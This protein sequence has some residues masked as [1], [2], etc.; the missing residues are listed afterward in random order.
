MT[1]SLVSTPWVWSSANHASSMATGKSGHPCP[2]ILSE[3]KMHC[4]CSILCQKSHFE[5]NWSWWGVACCAWSCCSSGQCFSNC[6]KS[7]V[8]VLPEDFSVTV[9]LSFVCFFN[10]LS[11]WIDIWLVFW[12]FFLFSLI[13]PK[14][15]QWFYNKQ[16]LCGPQI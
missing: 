8:T 3:I 16:I 6:H 9:K 14:Y 15:R 1:L 11:F 4:I 13:F 10:P 12:D 5:I 7:R 2:D